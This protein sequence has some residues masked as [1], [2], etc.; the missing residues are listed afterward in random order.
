ML[1]ELEAATLLLAPRLEGELSGHRV[2]G[3]ILLLEVR[4][5]GE[6]GRSALLLLHRRSSQPRPSLPRADL[7]VRE[8]TA[9]LYMEGF[10]V[11]PT[12]VEFV[13]WLEEQVFKNEPEVRGTVLEGFKYL[14]IDTFRKRFLVTFGTEQEL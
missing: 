7:E 8:N 13:E 1:Q 12:E 5:G 11:L 3:A 10:D 4:V 2:E 14:S 6:E 9:C